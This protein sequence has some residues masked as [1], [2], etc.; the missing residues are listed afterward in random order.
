MPFHPHPP[1]LGFG[2]GPADFTA[3]AAATDTDAAAGNALGAP[4]LGP[5]GG[6]TTEI[7]D[8][9][10]ETGTDA[11]DT[12]SGGTGND[13]LDGGAGDDT[14]AG[15]RGSDT[16]IGGDGDD[17]AD[18]SGLHG[19]VTFEV[20]GQEVYKAHYAA[21][22]LDGIEAIVGGA[23]GHNTIDAG[24]EEDSDEAQTISIEVDLSAETLTVHD[25]SDGSDT[26][27]TVVDFHNVVG[28]DNADSI[29]GDDGRNRLDG[30]EGD[31]TLAGGLGHNVL[32]GGD[33]ADTF[34]LDGGTDRIVDFDAD[35]GD[36][37]SISSSIETVE[38]G[39]HGAVV[40]FADGSSVQLVGIQSS[41]VDTGWFT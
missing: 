38:D 2:A 8:S 29:V 3:A 30:G 11:A 6:D 28:S 23:S 34:V 31:D 24:P 1:G 40:E 19:P 15:T 22:E 16:L 39:E 18:Y 7:D 17:T 20:E 4:E 26:T 13:S 10:L 25:S 41:D 32:R 37:I 12:L 5:I 35:E 27:Y 33:G 14:L 9:V 36:Q 21:D